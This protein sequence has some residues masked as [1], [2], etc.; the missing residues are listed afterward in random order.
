METYFIRSLVDGSKKKA[1][2]H[3]YLKTHLHHARKHSSFTVLFCAIHRHIWS[4]FI[5]EPFQDIEGALS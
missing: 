3:D 5:I 2:V 1:Y 4:N